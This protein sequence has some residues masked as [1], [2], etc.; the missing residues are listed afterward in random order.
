VTIDPAGRAL[1]VALG[2]KAEEVAVV[3]VRDRGRPQL[4]RRFRPPFLAHDVAFAPGGR[5]VWVSSGNRFELAVYDRRSGRLLARPSGDWPPQHVAFAGKTAY[6]TSGWSGTLR[7]HR[8]DGRPLREIP[9]PVGSYNVQH[10]LGRVVTPSLG[11]GT[12]TILDEQGR[13]L[14]RERVA[15]SS[16]DAS[17]VVGRV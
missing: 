5:H 6:V 16:H 4:V 15:R 12:L 7:L 17:L 1:W 11:H 13:L 10:G 3:D 2:S 14:R 8:S 9:V